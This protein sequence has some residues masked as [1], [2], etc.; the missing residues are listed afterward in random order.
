MAHA[1]VPVGVHRQNRLKRFSLPSLAILGPT[2]PA[3]ISRAGD[4]AD[5]DE[6]AEKVANRST[7]ANAPLCRTRRASSASTHTRTPA[8]MTGALRRASDGDQLRRSS[9]KW[10]GIGPPGP[11][12]EGDTDA[13]GS[14]DEEAGESLPS[15]PQPKLPSP[16]TTP[17]MRV[18][19][20]LFLTLVVVAALCT[21]TIANV[22]GTSFAAWGRE[23]H[24]LLAGAFRMTQPSATAHARPSLSP[25]QL[26]S[27]SG[28]EAAVVGSRAEGGPTPTGGGTKLFTYEL[29]FAELGI[30]ADQA[31]RYTDTING[32]PP[33]SFDE[34][35]LYHGVIRDLP[36]AMDSWAPG[37]EANWTAEQTWQDTEVVYL[38]PASPYHLCKAVEYPN[39]V[40]GAPWMWMKG[41]VPLS[42]SWTTGEAYRNA[43]A[44]ATITCPTFE[45]AMRWLFNQPSWKA[46][47]ERHVFPF[48]MSH[49]LRI[50][51]E[52]DMERYGEPRSIYAKMGQGI[53]VTAEDRRHDWREAIAAG[54]VVLAPYY[55]PPFFMYNGTVASLTSGKTIMASTSSSPAVNCHRF[56]NP[57]Q[58]KRWSCPDLAMRQARFMRAGIGAALNTLNSSKT[59]AQ[60]TRRRRGGTF[61]HLTD[62]LHEKADTYKSSVFCIIPPGDS[63]ITTR[64]YSAVQALCIPGA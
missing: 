35:G 24:N 23:A 19:R 45:R 7:E 41:V 8:P 43:I 28:E 10:T 55:S 9:R 33:P 64:I 50:A 3:T 51:L 38:F 22:P 5:S 2:A 32:D 16:T 11:G 39:K 58:P 26:P 62:I 37:G 34:G 17:I 49:V 6:D 4:G 29:P 48:I 13:S 40:W 53:I 42:I 56:D 18:R 25:V 12:V 52:S 1:D 15:S 46:A 63:A 21:L 31:R 47:P 14:S 54:R 44:N 60:V 57:R 36:R 61:D 27:G 59:S 30:P 20:S